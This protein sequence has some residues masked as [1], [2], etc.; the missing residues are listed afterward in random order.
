MN[1]SEHDSIPIVPDVAEPVLPSH[2][3]LHLASNLGT[4]L[5]VVQSSQQVFWPFRGM[6]GM[7]QRAKTIPLASIV[8]EAFASASLPIAAIR[9][10][11]MPR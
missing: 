10:S 5:R 6:A 9:P 1:S 4:N 3:G 8:R 2:A 7:D 11:R